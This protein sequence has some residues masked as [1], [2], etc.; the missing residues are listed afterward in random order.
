MPTYETV[1]VA[2]SH[3]KRIATVTMNRGEVHNAFNSQLVN[4]LK[5]AFSI[6]NKD[7]NL[8]V[9][10][11]TGAGK[12]FSAGA[13]L[14]MM[15]SA[16]SYS[17]E[18]NQREARQM[19][20]LFDLV[21]NCRVPIVARVNGTAMGGG[22][23]LIAACDIVIAADSARM[24][25][26]EVKLGIAPAVISPVVI[27]KIG[28][29]WARRLFITGERFTPALAREIGLVH[30]VVPLAELDTAVESMIQELLSSA[31]K[32]MRACKM[33]AKTIGQMEPI[34]ARNFTAETIARLRVGEEGQEGLKAFLE[35][36]Q[37]NWI[38]AKEE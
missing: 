3:N 4:D 37:P 20:S 22:L 23:G 18:D 28:A 2:Y 30:T 19:G 32:A 6:L 27:G 34:A 8:A 13:D 11:L 38:P 7:D 29:S 26:S 31:P 25:F 12:S 17:E 5:L 21:N 9:V 36:R 10:V 1:L 14:K 33:L 15:Q 16:A 24:S 35:K